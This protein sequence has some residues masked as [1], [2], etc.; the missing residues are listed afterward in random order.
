MGPAV[1]TG[2]VALLLL[3][4]LSKVALNRTDLVPAIIAGAGSIAAT[5][6]S[7][8]DLAKVVEELRATTVRAVLTISHDAVQV[9][10]VGLFGLIVFA[11]HCKK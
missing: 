2:M 9:V 3:K 4:D 1:I 7:V 5:L 11:V 6:L 10:V 8:K